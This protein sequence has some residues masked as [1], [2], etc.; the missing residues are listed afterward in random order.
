MKIRYLH[1]S[2]LHFVSKKGKKAVDAFNQDLVTSSM[3][4]KIKEFDSKVDFIIIT[5]DLVSFGIKDEFDIA[6]IFCKEVLNASDLSNRELFIVP[7]NHDLN[8]NSIDD[9]EKST[10][11]FDDQ[12]RVTKIFTNKRY[13][14]LIMEKFEEFNA[15]VSKVTGRELFNSETTG[16]FET[17]SINRDGQDYNIN[18]IGLNSAMFAGYKGDDK[19]KLALGLYQIDPWLKKIEDENI[20][21]GFFHHPFSCYHP[22]DKVCEKILMKQLD[23]ILTGHCHEPERVSLINSSGQSVLISAGASFKTRESYNSFNVVE[24]DTETGSGRVRFYKYRSGD[25]DWIEDRNV[26]PEEKDGS[27][28][29]QIKRIGESGKDTSTTL[30]KPEVYAKDVPARIVGYDPDEV[31]EAY[32]NKLINQLQ[33]LPLSGIDVGASDAENNREKMEL[34]SVYVELDTKTVVEKGDK[35]SGKGEDRSGAKET[36]PLSALEAVTKERCILIL[37]DPGSG[38][39]TFV[40][41]LALSFATQKGYADIKDD[42]G[43]VIWPEKDVLPIHI[44]LRDFVKSLPESEKRAEARHLWEFICKRLKDQRLEHA[45]EL[46]ERSLNNGTALVLLD[47][48]DE[49]A[50]KERRVFV[51]DAVNEFACR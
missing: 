25:N 47:G 45:D 20:R 38:K 14:P 2:D 9:I 46:V 5:G 51:R 6:E 32:R 11:S 43:K 28:P 13:F 17:L 42:E 36:R 35:K 23:I 39:S 44:V 34:D 48:L 8:R 49:I 16:F 24:I 21:I 18:L 1:I 4:K 40:N 31:L 26:T 37:G 22:A 3:I 33:R 30:N 29:F 19:Q 12:D 27:S 7:G 15:F 50:V 10:Y 41:H